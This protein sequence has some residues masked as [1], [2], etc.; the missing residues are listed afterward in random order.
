MLVLV[1]SVLAKPCQRNHGSGTRSTA[2]L[3]HGYKSCGGVHAAERIC[4]FLLRI[5][6]IAF[7]IVYMWWSVIGSLGQNRGG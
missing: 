6:L 2:L 5:L 4:C 7:D 3:P 1:W